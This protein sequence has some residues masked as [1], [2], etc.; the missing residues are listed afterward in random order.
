ME[1]EDLAPSTMFSELID[2]IDELVLVLD[3][4]LHVLDVN[5]GASVFFGY[6]KSELLAMRL[7]ALIEAGERD[8]ITDLCRGARERRGGDTVFITRSKSR[9][10][11]R[12][13]LSPFPGST[14]GPRNYLLVGHLANEDPFS[15]GTDA[16]NGLAARMLR[17]FADPIFIIDGASRT[18]QDCNGAALGTFGFAREELVGKRFM[19]QV[20]S[21]EERRRNRALEG[22]ADKAYASTGIF[23]ER[24]L[25]PRKGAPPLP[26]DLTALPF[27]RLDGTLASIV[28]MLF[29]R[30]A[31]E[32]REAQLAQLIGQ[33]N[34]LA[35]ELATAAASYST[36]GASKSL[37]DLGLTAR[38]V[39]IVRLIAEGSSSKD[40]GFRLGL[41]ES[42]VKNHLAAV[43]RKLKVG[44]RM[45][46]MRAIAALHIRIA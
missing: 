15:P 39:E 26:C 6:P 17:G 46:L 23:Q 38:Q 19:D 2:C 37:T 36:R 20:E 3:P 25:V 27:F 32:E 44:S 13:S 28:A 14:E 34:E 33:V 7:P 1:Q 4:D 5:R 8:R 16:S 45:D 40:A 43:Y 41:A 31:V 24:I 29:D 22:H 30:S 10:R 21:L 18:V 12:F 11:S 42:T 35:G 9:I